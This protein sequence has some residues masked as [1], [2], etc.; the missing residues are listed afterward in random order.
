MMRALWTAASGMI[1][2]QTNV[3]NISNNIANVNT[4]GFKKGEA[5][6]KSLLYQNLQTQST[7]SDNVLKPVNAQVGLGVRTAAITTVFTQGNLYENDYNLAFALEGEGFFKVRNQNGETLYTRSAAFIASPVEGGNMICTSDGMP[8]LDVNNQ[9]IIISDDYN[10]ME[11]SVDSEGKFSATNAQGDPVDLG[12]QFGLVQFNNPAGL[13]KVSGS[14]YKLTVAS[15]NPMEETTTQGL[16]QSRVR[17][18]YLE[19][20]N[21]QIVD[22]MVNL[23]V[24]QRAYEMNSKAITT[25][26]TMLEQANNLKR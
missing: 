2:Q 14:N 19:G 18:K 23:I 5:E 8:V 20:S 13:E 21:V 11:V 26:D 15:G 6:F 24:A 7:N 22:E 3:D 4:T 1:T 17:Q 25:A 10:A 16:T 9:A 12:I